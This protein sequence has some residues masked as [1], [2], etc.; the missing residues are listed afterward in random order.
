MVPEGKARDIAEAVR[1]WRDE[2]TI[3]KER[4]LYL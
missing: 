3:S 4:V 1:G 2:L